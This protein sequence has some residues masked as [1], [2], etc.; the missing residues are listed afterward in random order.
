[1]CGRY[2]AA[3]SV[4]DIAGAFGIRDDD[5]HADPSPDWNVAPTKTVPVVATHDGHTVLTEMR[6]GLVPSWADNP[7]VGPSMINARI[8]TVREKPAFRSAIVE[9]RCLLPADGWY[10]WQVRPDGVRQPHFL[11]VVSGPTAFAGIWE[12]WRDADGKRLVTAAILTGSA[13]DDL[14]HVHHRSPVVLEPHEWD[15]WLAAGDIDPDLLHPTRADLVVVHPVGLAVGD[16]R[17]NSAELVK[18]VKV[19]VQPELF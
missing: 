10:E 4:D 18:P 2:A 15:G 17:N 1:M 6:W 13:P 7:G 3:K 19:D 14:A 12:V 9:R 16:V 5:I 8:E 11:S